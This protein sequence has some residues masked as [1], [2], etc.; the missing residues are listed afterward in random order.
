[1]SLF[2]VTFYLRGE[3]SSHPAP[4]KTTKTNVEQPDQQIKQNLEP[5]DLKIPKSSHNSIPFPPSEEPQWQTPDG[6]ETDPV[7]KP[8]M[9]HEHRP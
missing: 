1:M 5:Q 4:E 8:N 9:G 3:G 2:L 6:L 7:I